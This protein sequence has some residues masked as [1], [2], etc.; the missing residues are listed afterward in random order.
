VPSMERAE[1]S[2]AIDV[3]FIDT[4]SLLSNGHKPSHQTTAPL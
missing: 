1:E 2:S 4:N 3:Y